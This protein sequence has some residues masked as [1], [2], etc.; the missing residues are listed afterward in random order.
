[1]KIAIPLVMAA[2][3]AVP[4]NASTLRIT[5]SNDASSAGF[6]LTPV[7]AAFHNGDFDSYNVGEAASPGLEQLAEVGN[8]GPVRDE[9]IAATTG[10]GNPSTGAVFSSFTPGGD[11]RPLFG[12]ESATV[13]VEITNRST[14][15]FFSFLSMV[16][17]TNDLFIG[18]GNPLAFELFDDLGNFTGDRTITVTGAAIRDAGTEVNDRTTGVAFAAGQDGAAGATEGGVVIENGYAELI[19][20]VGLDTVAGFTIDP[21][22]KNTLL[23]TPANEFAVATI[24]ISE[25]AAIPLPAGG[26]LLLSALG[27]GGLLARRKKAG[28]REA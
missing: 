14:Q 23:D 10:N 28:A 19:R 24:T 6:A 3:L 1:M 12:G 8:F 13:D 4:A 11:R 9:R 17:P 22:L 21:N 16:I 18:N 5:I 25:V 2:L 27:I 7:Y 26:F 15:R 20:Y